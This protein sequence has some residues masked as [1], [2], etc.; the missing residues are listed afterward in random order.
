MDYESVQVSVGTV[1]WD[2][3]EE[4]YDQGSDENDGHTLVFVTLYRGKD[5][6]VRPK[7]GVAHG[8]KIICH[9]SDALSRIPPKGA[10][11]YVIIPHGMEDAVGAGC[12]VAC[13]SKSPTVQFDANRVVMDF[14]P[15]THV[16][17]KGKSVTLSDHENPGRFMAVGT[18]K[19]GGAAGVQIRLGDGTGA[20]WQDGACGLFVAQNGET[21]T[22]VQATPSKF[23]VWQGSGVIKL[24]GDEF[25]A[26]APTCKVQGNVFLGKGVPA[27]LVGTGTALYG[28]TGASAVPSPSVFLSSI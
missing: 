22:L 19:S 24:A 4:W 5:P 17:I 6:D 14:G 21:K 8:Q 9:I 1:G 11:C 18:P 13:V 25:T 16:I 26:L 3:R 10:R 28:A 23:E 7:A 27:G 20:V 2:D 12:I 15:D